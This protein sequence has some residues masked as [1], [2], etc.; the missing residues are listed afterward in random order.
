MTLKRLFLILA[1]ICFVLGWIEPGT[2]WRIGTILA[3]L[4][5][6]FINFFRDKKIDTVLLISGFLADLVAFLANGGKM[7]VLNPGNI[8]LDKFHVLL[9]T[10]SRL[11]FL[12]DVYRINDAAVFS[13]GDFLICAW[14]VVSIALRVF[15]VGSRRHYVPVI[16][17]ENINAAREF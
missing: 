11:P 17:T 15:T 14:I 1:V 8:S 4:A 3:G 2:W 9:T 7:P 12:C 16:K 6:A 13:A 10:T 5:W